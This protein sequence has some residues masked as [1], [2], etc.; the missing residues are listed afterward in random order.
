[1]PRG[2]PAR[3]D[4]QLSSRVGDLSFEQLQELPHR[5]ISTGSGELAVGHHSPNVEI[6]D[7]NDPTGPC[8]FG[9]ERVLDISPDVGNLLMLAGHLEPLFLIIRT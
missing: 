7:A 6:F 5:Y 3:G 1:M 2:K 8:Q 9:G 4:E